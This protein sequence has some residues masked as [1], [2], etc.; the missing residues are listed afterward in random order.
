MGSGHILVYAFDVLMQIYRESGYTDRE[1]SL[2][3]LEHNLYGMDIDK[4]AYQLAYFALMMKAR[5]YNRHLFDKPIKTNL[6]ALRESNAIANDSLSDLPM[7]L[8]QREIAKKLVEVFYNAEEVGSLI[9]VEDLNYGDLIDALDQLQFCQGQIDLL[10]RCRHQTT[11]P[12]LIDLASQA[13]LLAGRYAVVCTNPPYM[14]KF[15]TYFKKYAKTYYKD[16]SRDLFSMFIYRNFGLCREDGYTAFMTPNVWLY[17]KSYAKLRKYII[18]QKGIVTLVEMAKGAF[19]KEATVDVCAFVLSNKPVR[20]PGLYFILD[21]FKGD[22]TVQKEKVLAGLDAD[23]C[24]YLYEAETA[25]FEN[26]PA[27]RSLLGSVTRF[28]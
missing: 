22:M 19:Y 12:L 15:D 18:S 27:R 23:D 13:D 16:Y 14:N 26:C 7:T 24:S 28:K 3:I 20:R 1:A 25:N 17:I 10:T 21:E 2:N 5:S 8:E 9:Q 4:Q 6:V 11:L